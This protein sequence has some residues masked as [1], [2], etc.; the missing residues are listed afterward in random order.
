[1]LCDQHTIFTLGHI[2]YV[3][4]DKEYTQSIEIA[5]ITPDVVNSSMYYEIS[6][7]AKDAD[8]VYL[9]IIVLDKVYT[10]TLK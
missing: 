6:G 3:I 1:M 4:D 2:R 7:D 10:Y 9:D 5:N 8:K